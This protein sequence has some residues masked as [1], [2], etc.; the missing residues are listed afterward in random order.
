MPRP[1][2]FAA[3]LA[4]VALAALAIRSAYA[5]AIRDHVVQGDA[6]TFRLVAQGLADGRGFDDAF[7]GGPTA[8]HPPALYVFLAALDRLGLNGILVHRLALGVVGVVVVVLVGL[9]ARRLFG[10]RVGLVAAGLAALYPMLWTA[11]GALL[12]ETLY[13]VSLVGALLLAVGVRERPTA[14]RAAALG[15]VIALAALT[16]GEALAL[17][18]LLLVPLT[19][20][21]P[22]ALAAGLAAFALV[23]APWTIRNLATFEEPVLVSTNSS[24]VF[25]GANCADTYGGALLGSWQFRCYTP[26]RRGEDEARY[27]S[28]QRAIGLAYAREHAGRLPVVVAARL[29]RLLDVFEVEQSVF[30]NNGEGRPVRYVRWAIRAYWVVGLLALAGLAVAV[31]RRRPGLWVL[32][33]PVAM[34]VFVAVVTYGGTRF[35]YAAEPSLVVLAA[36]ALV[37]LVPPIRKFC[38]I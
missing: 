10:E 11:D 18:V 20:R 4:F 13:G 15:A 21:R 36:V 12:S 16:R 6:L 34:V 24:G 22:R 32:L 1:T 27:F 33:A 9:L 38:G 26:R 31:R 29:G 25:V 2:A 5:V 3:R 35:R 28:R 14:R 19:G 30:L 37:A 8:E 23:L 17:V 7:V